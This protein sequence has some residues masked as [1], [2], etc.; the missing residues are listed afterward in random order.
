MT[1]QTTKEQAVEVLRILTAQH[2]KKKYFL[3][4]EVVSHDIGFG[5]DLRV[6]RALW[7]GE[8]VSAPGSIDRVPICVLLVGR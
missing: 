3:K 6:D 1:I 5:I 8:K 4:A 7:Q 2:A